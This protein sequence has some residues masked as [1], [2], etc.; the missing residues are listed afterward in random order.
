M[1]GT[2][3]KPVTRAKRSNNLWMTEEQTK[4]L[5]LSLKVTDILHQERTP[6]QDI[7]V[8]ETPE[9]GRALMLDGAIQLTE[10]DE[11][12]YSEMM[13]HVPICAHPDPRRVLIV[14]GGDGA[15]LREVLRHQDGGASS[16][17][18]DLDEDAL[19]FVL[20][21]DVSSVTS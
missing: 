12:C 19:P 21:P 15:I 5:R 17:D 6:W 1:S 13:A 14:G 4:N 10:R 7:L 16:F 8:V 18:A 11:F 3:E 9:Y 20:G 2:D